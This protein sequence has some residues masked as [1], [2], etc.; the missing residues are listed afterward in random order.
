MNT[1]QFEILESKILQAL[2][3]IHKLRHENASLKK[4]IELLQSTLKIKNQEIEN[5]QR[6]VALNGPDQNIVRQF[7][8]RE[9]RIRDK[10][11]QML[12]KL[13]ALDIPL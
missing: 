7:Q 11:E 13:E 10:I 3:V 4:E 6:K 5:L 12:A 2:D 1:Q 8:E 9:A